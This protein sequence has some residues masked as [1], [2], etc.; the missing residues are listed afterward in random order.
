MGRKRWPRAICRIEDAAFTHVY[1]LAGRLVAA[2]F[3]SPAASIGQLEEFEA[4]RR[5]YDDDRLRVAPVKLY[6]DDVIGH[7]TAAL[8]EPYADEPA[9]RGGTF[10]DP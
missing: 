8:F 1:A 9:T 2:L 10:Y 3:L 5:R 6:I 4:A 7:H